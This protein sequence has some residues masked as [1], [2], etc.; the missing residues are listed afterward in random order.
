M[1]GNKKNKKSH[2]YAVANV[3]NAQQTSNS[4]ESNGHQDI[5]NISAK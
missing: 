4:S 5:S 1:G 2:S 3:S